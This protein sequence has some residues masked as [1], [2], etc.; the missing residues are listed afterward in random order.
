M[1]VSNNR[2]SERISYQLNLRWINFLIPVSFVILA[3]VLWFI[4]RMAADG[5]YLPLLFTWLAAIGVYLVGVRSLDDGFVAEDG[6]FQMTRRDWLAVGLLTLGALALRLWNLESIP[7]T[8]S[9]DEASQGLEGLRVLSGELTNPFTTGWYTVPTLSFFFNS[10]F[11]GLIES[12]ILGMRV[13]YAIIGSLSVPLAYVF[14]SQLYGRRYGLLTALFMMFFHFHIHYSRLG[15][16]QI[17]DTLLMLAALNFGYHGLNKS[18]RPHL[19]WALAGVVSALGLYFYAGARLTVLLIIG[20]VLVYF[21]YQRRAFLKAQ[22]SG[23]LTFVGGYLVAGGPILQYARRFPDDFNGRLNQTGIFQSGWLA[24]EVELSGSSMGEILFDQFLRGAFSMNFYQDR[25]VW[26]RPDTQMLDP[27]FGAL[28]LLG[29]G[30]ICLRAFRNLTLVPVAAWWWS[31]VIL[32]AALLDTTPSSQRLITLAIPVCFAI[33]YALI[34]L[35]KLSERAFGIAPDRLVLPL[36]VLLFGAYNLNFYFNVYSPRQVYGGGHAEFATMI[37]PALREHTGEKPVY[38][39]GNRRVDWNFA[40][41]P[42]LS[43]IP[44]TQVQM[45]DDELTGPPPQDWVAPQGA[46]FIVDRERA[47]ELPLIQ[48]AFPQGNLIRL[49]SPG[50]SENTAYIYIVEGNR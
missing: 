10:I 13:P 32:G 30:L 1:A 11:Q 40:S 26:Y 41:F 14:F 43:K 29:L 18:R 45:V 23:L 4:P 22:W 16:V 37:A 20:L 6:H 49:D 35:M 28:F 46:V 15:S 33:A 44:A 12:R 48:A 7:Y 31:G 9:G 8:F 24:R 5:N 34:E 36:A 47:A 2:V 27:V 42:F 50:I 39:L 19:N 38:F 21:V 17:G 25:A 3:V